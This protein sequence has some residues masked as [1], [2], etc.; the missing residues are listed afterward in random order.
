M[1]WSP[2]SPDPNLT[3][4]L[5]ARFKMELYGEGKQYVSLNRVWEAV[6]AAAQTV[7]RQQVMNLT[8]WKV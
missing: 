3:E 7:D 4:N 5:W 8:E 2:S 1:T 6:S